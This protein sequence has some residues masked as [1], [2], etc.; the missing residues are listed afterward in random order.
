MKARIVIG[1]WPRGGRTLVSREV[2]HEN[3]AS[4]G[5]ELHTERREE[6]RTSMD[7]GADP[8]SFRAQG[9][10]IFASKIQKRNESE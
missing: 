10:K 6:L 2:T 3:G 4:L 7:F 9:E 1:N 8:G 5:S